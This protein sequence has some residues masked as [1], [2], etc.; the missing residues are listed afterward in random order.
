[1]SCVTFHYRPQCVTVN[2]RE[3]EEIAKPVKCDMKIVRV[4]FQSKIHR[5][6]C[7]LNDNQEFIKNKNIFGRFLFFFVV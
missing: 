5:V 3:C 4:P 6:K 1:M 2:Y 7:L